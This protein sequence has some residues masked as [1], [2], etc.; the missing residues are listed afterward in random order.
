MLVFTHSQTEN[1]LYVN[2]SL[3]RTAAI[4]GYTPA[5]CFAP[6]GSGDDKGLMFGVAA[7]DNPDRSGYIDG[8]LEEITLLDFA[9]VDADVATLYNKGKN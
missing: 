9:L 1:K 6:T 4:S 7:P 8:V 3:V 5:N 2:G